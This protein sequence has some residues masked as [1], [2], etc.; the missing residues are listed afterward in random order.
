MY[1]IDELVC[2]LYIQGFRALE[3]C[4]HDFEFM[5]T[6]KKMPGKYFNFVIIL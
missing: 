3:I 2:T 1:G 4:F 5:Q 6:V